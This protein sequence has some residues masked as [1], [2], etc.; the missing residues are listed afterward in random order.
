M[1]IKQPITQNRM[2]NNHT[3]RQLFRTFN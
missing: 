2:Y 1:E 3:T